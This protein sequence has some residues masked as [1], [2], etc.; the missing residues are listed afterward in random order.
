MSVRALALVLAVCAIGACGKKGPPLPPLRYIPA[1]PTELQ[2][3]RTGDD[4]RLQFRLPTANVQG[5]GQIALDRLEVFAVTV[6]A[7]SNDPPNRELLDAKYRVATI[8]VKPPAQ[9]GDL[10]PSPDAPPDTRPAPGDIATFVEELNAATLTP[11]I[12]TPAAPVVMPTEPSA[13]AAA[14]AAVAAAQKIVPVT[15]R[16]YVVRGLTRGGRA[17][18][19]STR[20]VLP[21]V[22]LPLPPAGVDVAYDEKAITVSWIAPVPPLDQVAPTFNVYREGTPAPLNP[23]PL[24]TTTFVREGVTFGTEECFTVR[25]AVAAANVTLESV[26]TAPACVTP[27]DTFPPA[28]PTGLSAVGTEGAINLIWERNTDADLAGYLVLRGE[29]PGDT[30]QAITASP[31]QE[32]TYRDTTVTP[33]VRYVYAIVAVDRAT[34]PNTSA[35]SNRVEESAR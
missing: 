23:A 20:I 26:P 8:P 27:V 5:Q 13:A 17:G 7:E 3:R 14:A 12:T 31:I 24:S 16:I 29:A 18:Q 4:V 21:L 1:A 25:T 22:D 30:L 10:E 28:A 33:G 2:A 35:Q 32:T 6:A 9:E 34:P 19:P 11:Q 15:R